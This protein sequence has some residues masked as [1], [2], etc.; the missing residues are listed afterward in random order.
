MT[1]LTL[2]LSAI[3]GSATLSF[4]SMEKSA[5]SDHDLLAQWLGEHREAAFH[6]LVARYTALVHATARRTCRDE[7]IATEASQLTFITL[8]AKASSLL[9]CASL[10]GW[11]HATSMRHAKNLLR[12]SQRESRKRHQLLLAMETAPQD[13]ASHSVWK[14]MEPMLDEALA[15]LPAKDREAL[16][17]R[18]YRSLSIREIAT[19]LGIATA[20]AQKRVDRATERLRSHLARR[21]CHA[22]TTIS[23]AM[24]TG[25]AADAQAA[26]PASS[27][28]ASKALIAS[29][30]ATAGI[31]SFATLTTF[32]TATAVKTTSFVPPLVALLAAATWIS[33]Q[34]RSLASVEN[35]SN[36][37]RQQLTSNPAAIANPT[38]SRGT[39][40]ASLLPTDWKELAA[41][42]T[43]PFT[44]RQFQ[45]QLEKM[46][47]TELVQSLREVAAINLLQGERLQLEHLLT[48]QLILSDPKAVLTN[49]PGQIGDTGPLARLLPR[50][51]GAWMTKEPA[52]SITWLDAQIAAGNLEPLRLDGSNGSRTAFEAYAVASLLSSDPAAASLRVKA[53]TDSE[54]AETIRFAGTINTMDSPAAFANLAREQLDEAAAMIAI[55]APAGALV[56]GNDYTAISQ[57]LDAIQATPAERSAC[58][59]VAVAKG[60]FNIVTERKFVPDDLRTVREWVSLQSPDRLGEITGQALGQVSIQQNQ[61][62]FREL[63]SLVDHFHEAG[64]GDSIIIAFLTNTYTEQEALKKLSRDLAGKVTDEARRAELLENI[65]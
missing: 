22:G 10:G 57:Y 12:K 39:F 11:L 17:L 28:V 65:Q 5:P 14:D 23:A 31:G 15:A 19:T 36:R 55:Q 41:R 16:L 46:S 54:R 42:L 40:T 26:L 6:T 4:R 44:R 53:L 29:S 37:L 47:P 48:T 21:G 1:S 60:V 51:L 64:D 45:R 24:I 61:M 13:P 3:S 18:F 9:S 34:R 49:F 56:K 59:H 27:I 58:A 8:A 50:A 35:E 62:P 63:I 25:F 30:A 52:E 2:F 43:D 33:T 32:L 38:T 20:A 7:S